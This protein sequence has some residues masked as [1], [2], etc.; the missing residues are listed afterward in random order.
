MPE[1]MKPGV[2]DLDELIQM[3]EWGEK[4]IKKCA[5]LRKKVRKLEK[6]IERRGNQKDG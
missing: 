2:S 6:E 4:M 3:R 1:G 5:K